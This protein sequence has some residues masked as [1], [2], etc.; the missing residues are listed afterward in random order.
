MIY[1]VNCN[2]FKWFAKQ[3]Y[4]HHNS[5]KQHISQNLKRHCVLAWYVWHIKI[6]RK[7]ILYPTLTFSIKSLHWFWQWRG[8][9]WLEKESWSVVLEWRRCGIGVCR[10][11][12]FVYLSQRRRKSFP[13]FF[14]L[15]AHSSC[16]AHQPDTHICTLIESKARIRGS[17]AEALKRK[18]SH[19]SSLHSFICTSLQ[20]RRKKE[21]DRSGHSEEV[22]STTLIHSD[23]GGERERACDEVSEKRELPSREMSKYPPVKKMDYCIYG[24]R[25]LYVNRTMTDLEWCPLAEASHAK[26][27]STPYKITQETWFGLI[28]VC[29][30]HVVAIRN[31]SKFKT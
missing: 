16:A 5:F 28:P 2:H 1:L 6:L 31:F 30:W 13:E 10:E 20:L 12:W 26:R 4:F 7:R 3:F 19:A 24:F 11:L 22:D 9:P 27:N 8:F 14:A 21:K 17:R 23:P 18:K 15:T 29:L 25:F